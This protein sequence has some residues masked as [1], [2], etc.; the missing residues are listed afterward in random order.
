MYAVVG[1]GNPGKTY[2]NTFHNA[3]FWVLDLLAIALGVNFIKSSL[4]ATIAHSWVGQEK[5]LLAKPTTYM[6]LSGKAVEKI[7]SFYKINIQ[8]LIVVRDDIDME[9]GK[10]KLKRNSSS[11][12]HKGVQSIIDTLGSKA[13][14]QIKIGV[15]KNGNAADFVLKEL[16]DKQKKILKVS[17]KIASRACIKTIE[18]GLEKAANMYNNWTYS[19]NKDSSQDLCALN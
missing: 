4:E 14:I 9:L 11:G 7:V 6:N 18:E 3:G 2:E 1:L 12:G 15:G 17:A 10:I 16:D 19:E 8:N 5:V 13:F